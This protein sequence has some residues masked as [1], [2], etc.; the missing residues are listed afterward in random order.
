MPR[1]PRSLLAPGFSTATGDFTAR[2][3][4][5]RT[6]TSIRHLAYKRL[7]HQVGFYR[8]FEDRCRQIR[9]LNLL[10]VDIDHIYLHRCSAPKRLLLS[11]F[12]NHYHP[13]S[14]TWNTAS[15]ADQVAV[16][17]DPDNLYILRG[18]SDISHM[19]WST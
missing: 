14:R 19:A 18:N 10:A 5:M 17:V 12:L 7:V 13:A 8:G 3:G 11:G 2:L 1:T 4:L 6:Q 16:N 15:Y 9:S